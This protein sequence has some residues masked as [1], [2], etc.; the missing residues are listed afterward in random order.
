MG[1]RAYHPHVEPYTDWRCRFSAGGATSRTRR[2]VGVRE[3]E[4]ERNPGRRVTE[5]MGENETMI[6]G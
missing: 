4:T 3:R 2:E 5:K 1:A 6:I